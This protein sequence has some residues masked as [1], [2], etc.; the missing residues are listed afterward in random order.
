WEP[1]RS[2]NRREVSHMRAFVSVALLPV[3]VVAAT[4]VSA[5]DEPQDKGKWPV[6]VD[7]KY[8]HKTFR[9][10]PA[11]VGYR[12]FPRHGHPEVLAV[13]RIKEKDIPADY[14]MTRV[15][16]FWKEQGEEHVKKLLAVDDGFITVDADWVNLATPKAEWGGAPE[17]WVEGR[18][19]LGELLTKLPA[20]K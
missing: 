17:L 3:L 15:P 16:G 1:W 7:G 19:L 13:F 11:A 9:F 12:G 5:A 20:K 18:P 2:A 10:R 4:R 14:F 6:Y 8:T